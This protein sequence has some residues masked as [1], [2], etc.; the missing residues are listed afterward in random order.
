MATTIAWPHNCHRHGDADQIV[1]SDG[2]WQA[3]GYQVGEQITVSGTG[4]GF[5]QASWSVAVEGTDLASPPEAGSDGP[6]PLVMVFHGYG[7]SKFGLD[8]LRH[9][10]EQGYAAFSMLAPRNTRRSGSSAMIRAAPVI[11]RPVERKP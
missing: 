5:C 4:F 9:W 7:G 6:Y 10:T 11:R 1:L 8:R 3:K 2:T